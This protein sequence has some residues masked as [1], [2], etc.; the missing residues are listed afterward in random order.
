MNE[1]E[2]TSFSG[3]VIAKNTIYNLLGYG[4]PFVFALVLIPFLLNGLGTEKF[5]ILNLVWIV[6]G[7]F[8]F[9]D[10][11]IG[12]ALTKIIA[13][14]IGLNQ[15]NQIPGFFWT[16]L[17]LMFI[18]SLFGSFVLILVTPV[19]VSNFFKIS[20]SLQNE[21]LKTFYLLALSIP[22]V[23]TTAGIR[24]VLEAY[25]RFGIINVI[26]VILG[27]S[28][29]LGPVICL[30]FTTDLFW[31][32]LFLTLIRIVIWSLYINQCFKLHDKF[33][34]SFCFNLKLVKPI[35]RISGWLTVTNTI[36]PLITYLDRFLIGILIS[37]TAVVYY[38][39]P[40]EVIT[41]LLVIPTA[42]IAVLFP[43][44]SSSYLQNS[45]ISKKLFLRGIKF[46][47]LI[48]FPIVLSIITFS[49]EGLNLWLGK[50]F[51]DSS[52][53]ILQL[54]CIGILLNSLAQIP[55][56][57][58]Q[59]VGRP[60]IP[61]ILNLLELPFYL[62]AMWF[63]ISEWGIDG[64]IFIWLLRIL[65]DTFILIFISNKFIEIEY[66]FKSGAIA[67][68]LTG[69][70]LALPIF[71]THIW[72]KMVYVISVL[73]IFIHLTWKYFLMNDEK[74]FLFQRLRELGI[75]K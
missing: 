4:I 15:I 55:F 36:G 10:F 42:L 13:E 44:F 39:T 69:F 22:I 70:I 7:Y 11:G 52:T 31:I 29:F 73:I 40:Y 75:I 48:L 66:T 49:N 8:S 17:I 65:I 19:L 12:R 23:T 59:S 34:N 41:K 53:L 58:L 18:I 68:L 71:M 50:T 26:R 25:Q 1:T 67:S 16:S 20:P 72:L 3:T 33:K 27:I 5:G 2:N 45:E 43:A 51:A 32:V 57:Y 9:F 38:A 35:L 6:I 14:K 46:I 63:A 60:D 74:M 28:S 61:A 21:T 37:A 56:T 47:F 30:F 54:L 62:I 64:V 24:G